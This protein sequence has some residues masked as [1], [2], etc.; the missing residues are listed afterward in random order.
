MKTRKDRAVKIK[1]VSRFHSTT[2][3]TAVCVCDFYYYCIIVLFDIKI[4]RYYS[5]YYICMYIDIMAW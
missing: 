5:F 2:N 4:V 1:R 3:K